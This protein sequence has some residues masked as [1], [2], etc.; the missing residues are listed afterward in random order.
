MAVSFQINGLDK[1]LAALNKAPQIVSQTIRVAIKKEFEEIDR[2][3][4]A[5]HHYTTHT[6]KLEQSIDSSVSND[7]L[8]A[9]IFLSK[10]KAPAPYA[11]R[12][13][14][15][16]VDKY[17]VLGR[18]FNGPQPDPFLYNAVKHRKSDL[19]KNMQKAVEDGFRKAGL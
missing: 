16:F 1:Y 18:H 15:G 8:S 17:D 13:H 7:G 5:N 3:A 6:G 9:K 12:I 19:I 10:T 2:Y 14:E 11:W 4:R